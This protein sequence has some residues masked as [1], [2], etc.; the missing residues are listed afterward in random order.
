MSP[1]RVRSRDQREE[2]GLAI[3][4]C[5]L[6]FPDL[7]GDPASEEAIKELEGDVALTIRRYENAIASIRQSPKAPAEVIALL[8]SHLAEHR[9]ELAQLEKATAQVLAAK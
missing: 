6:D 9:Q 5:F 4:G 1:W 2:V 8:E 3:L 7:I